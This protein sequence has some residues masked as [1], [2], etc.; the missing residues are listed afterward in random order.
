MYKVDPYTL[1][2]YKPLCIPGGIRTRTRADYRHLGSVRALYAYLDRKPH[3]SDAVDSWGEPA[4][5]SPADDCEIQWRDTAI[6]LYDGGWTH[7]DPDDTTGAADPQLLLMLAEPLSGYYTADGESVYLTSDAAACI[8]ATIREL[9][10]RD[11]ESGEEAD[12]L[13][14]SL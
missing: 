13:G 12:A 10:E 6:A 7:S 8:L 9:R 11:A 14:A 4:L 2:E 3:M 1:R 5:R